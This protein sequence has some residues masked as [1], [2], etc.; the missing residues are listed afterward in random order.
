MTRVAAAL[1]LALLVVGCRSK[2][3]AASKHRVPDASA[4]ADRSVVQV[5]AGQSATWPLLDD[6]P[7]AVADAVFQLSPDTS[8][9]LLSAVGPVEIDGLVVVGS[10]QLGFV[11]IDM[12][13]RAQRWHRAT[14]S[15]L[16]PPLAAVDGI[17]LV[18]DCALPPAPTRIGIGQR[19]LGCYRV[20]SA[21]GEERIAA[22]ISGDDAA[23]AAF[24][25]EPGPSAL[26]PQTPDRVRW[27]RGEYAVDFN[28]T[29]GLAVPASPTPAGVTAR[30]G[31]RSWQIR[32][33]EDALDAI[34]TSAMSWKVSSRFAALL[35]VIPGAGYEV[36]TVRVA[37]LSGANGQGQVELLDIDATGS[38]RG[39][40]AHPIPGIVVLA[41]T[42]RAGDTALAVRLDTS[43]RHDYIAAFDRRAGLRWVWPLPE[44][45][46]VDPIGLAISDTK[47]Y[48][49]FDG[50]HIAVLPL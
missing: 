20:L 49:F 21:D 22:P 15:R 27:Q 7:R 16:A 36:P 8:M 29:T 4:S 30:H 31:K 2:H 34:G 37:R 3:K 39:H 40:A 25:S 9:P 41:H 19:L 33:G 10:S 12:E 17:L 26:Y 14:G 48:A 1:A 46:R 45:T 35:G 18:S 38:R 6:R 44:S 32:L 43:L 11:A 13:R 50:A 5:D 42:F 24:A 47:V 28:I 23:V